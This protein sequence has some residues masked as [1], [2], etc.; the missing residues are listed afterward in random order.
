MTT[1]NCEIT[2]ADI[3]E[4]QRGKEALK[5]LALACI[6]RGEAGRDSSDV[7][8]ALLKAIDAMTNLESTMLAEPEP[9]AAVIERLQE[10]MA[11]ND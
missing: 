7:Y 10:E 9:A 3:R 1:S 5:N 6:N 4:V 11:S 2:F 8:K